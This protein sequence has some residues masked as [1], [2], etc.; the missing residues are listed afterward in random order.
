MTKSKHHV[1]TRCLDP[2]YCFF[3]T[4]II[5]VDRYHMY[6]FFFPGVFYN[7]TGSVSDKFPT[8]ITP[9]G[10]TFSIWGVIYAWQALFLV[11]SLSTICRKGFNDAYLYHDPEICPGIIY[12]LYV[13]NM[14]LNI[15]WLFLWD[16][17]YFIPSFVVIA[18]TPFTLFVMLV[19]SCRAVL[20]H[21]LE[22]TKAGMKKEIW[23]IRILVHNAFGIYATWTS[24][25][26]LLNLSIMLTHVSEI[27]LQKETSTTISL[28]IL[29]VE[30][31]LFSFFDIILLDR[32][33]RYL[34]TP[35]LVIPVALVGILVKNW[36][37]DKRNSILTMTLLAAS[38]ILLAMKIVV[39]TWRSVK[40]PIFT[41]DEAEVKTVKSE[42]EV[43]I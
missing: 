18:L 39:M 12:L 16:R 27:S 7:S 15:T 3:F 11:Y 26:T 42:E 6:T 36:S 33:I 19:F 1:K 25:A 43:R 5:G 30:I 28:V 23:L 13:I 24:I 29:I 2:I 9:T 8:D 37:Q 38:A 32:Y 34:F 40:K 20:K 35:Y 17:Q 21:G 14:G 41:E 31:L 10:W 4:R 22:L